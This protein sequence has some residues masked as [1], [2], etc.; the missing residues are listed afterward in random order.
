[1]SD[2]ETADCEAIAQDRLGPSARVELQFEDRANYQSG[3]WAEVFVGD[4][5]LPRH[6]EF[7]AGRPNALR[8]L[9]E[10]LV[11]NHEPLS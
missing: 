6:R 2:Q 1:M 9:Q 10:W 3:W 5:T 11:A 8:K 7:N 4:E